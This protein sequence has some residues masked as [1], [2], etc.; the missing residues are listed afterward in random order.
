M[1]TQSPEVNDLE[2]GQL[3]YW[4]I[5]FFLGLGFERHQAE[6]LDLA[7]VD[8]HDAEDLLADGC[9]HELAMEILT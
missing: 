1:K 8:C 5:D 7:N 4:H 9:S 3:H 2:D 6:I